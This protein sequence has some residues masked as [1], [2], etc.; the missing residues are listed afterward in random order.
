MIELTADQE[1]CVNGEN[2]T[3]DVDIT[4]GETGTGVFSGPG[5]VDPDTGVFDPS[6]AN[7]GINT[8][9][10]AFTSDAAGCVGSKT[11]SI[12]VFE[13]PVASY[14]QNL[15]TMCIT[16]ILDI[17]YTGTMNPQTFDWDYDGGLGSGL[18]TDQQVTFDSPG[19]KIITLQVIKNGCPSNIATSSVLVEPELEVVTIQCDTAGSDFVTFSWN[20]ING[21][22]LFEVTIDNNP[23][24]FSPN[25]TI[26]IDNLDE[27]Q[28]VS[29]SVTSL[30][31]TSC[32]GSTSSSL[33]TT[34]KTV[35]VED[36]L[37]SQ[38]KI[39]PN[40]VTDHLFFGGVV[41][42]GFLFSMYSIIGRSVKSG[43][44][45]SQAIDISSLTSGIYI[46]RVT[47]EK[48]GLFKDFKVVK[49]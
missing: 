40:P 34:T 23:S 5:I 12:E 28:E 36:Q 17:D 26:T 25:N 33:C 10:Y 39:Y 24:I 32:P 47:D 43:M 19:L 45:S 15:D 1:V 13:V 37:L 21:V 27:E 20:L 35:A 41:D 9:L 49:E 6:M 18:L 2:V 48:R 16:D 22:S 14:D 31:I 46:L 44:I 11:I 38:I 29:I 42:E 8:I 7:I 4:S 3:I 30:S